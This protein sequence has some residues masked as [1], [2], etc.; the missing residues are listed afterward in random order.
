MFRFLL[1]HGACHRA[2]AWAKVIATLQD[3]GHQAQAVDLIGETLDANAQIILDAIDGPTIL[4][5]HSAGGFAITAAALRDPKSVQGLIYLCAYIPQIGK[6]VAQM[7]RDGPSQPLARAFQIAADRKT[8]GFDPKL[9]QD[10]FFH[11]CPC[12]VTLAHDPIAPM[13]TA[14]AALPNIA[15]AAIFCTKDRAIPP[16]YQAE[17][18]KG[19][20]LCA[21]LLCGHAPFFAM[22]DA[23]AQTLVAQAGALGQLRR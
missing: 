12:D 22:P 20:D 10:L 15:R 2:W 4:V 1:V 11:D 7:R 13:E 3:L 8:Y 9:V 6:S 23:L 5:G 17:M 19:I 21:E 18:A 16:A 14:L